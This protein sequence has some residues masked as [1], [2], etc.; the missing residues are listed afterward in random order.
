MR[1]WPS[2]GGDPDKSD[3]RSPET[4]NA[5]NKC[6]VSIELNEIIYIYILHQTRVSFFRAG[7]DPNQ[8]ILKLIP[9][10]NFT[11]FYIYLYYLSYVWK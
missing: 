3:P 7:I 5:V 2:E 8:E 11:L 4:E 9:L 10:Q 6:G 1:K